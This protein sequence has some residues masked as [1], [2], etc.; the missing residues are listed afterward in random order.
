MRYKLRSE[1]KDLD[2]VVSTEEEFVCLT[3]A[4]LSLGFE[5]RTPDID[6]Y[7]RMALSHIL[8]RGSIRV[9]LF[10]KLV[11]GKFA[12]SDGMR[13]RASGDIVLN[14]VRLLICSLNDIF[15]FKCMT[16][17]DGDLADCQKM[18]TDYTLDWNAVLDEA[19]KQSVDEH[20]V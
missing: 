16:E 3:D 9:D 19:V 2:I 15:L 10:C 13:E 14:K 5:K 17:R 11:C 1:T 12:L 20:S 6:A 4:L 18:A 7:E 8:V